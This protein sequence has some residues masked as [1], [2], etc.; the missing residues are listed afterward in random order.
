[1]VSETHMIDVTD[2]DFFEKCFCP[3]NDENRPETI[4]F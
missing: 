3:E 2:L 4:L 1:M